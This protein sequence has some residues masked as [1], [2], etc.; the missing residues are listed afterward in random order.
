[1]R[2]ADHPIWRT[3]HYGVIITVIGVV[4]WLNAVKFDGEWYTLG[5][6]ALTIVLGGE[7]TASR[8]RVQ[9]QPRQGET[10]DAA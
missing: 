2:D 7:W 5:A 4:M 10:D 1:M 8:R 9:P 3:I 6:S